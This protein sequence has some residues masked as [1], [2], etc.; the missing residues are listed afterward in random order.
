[1]SAIANHIVDLMVEKFEIPAESLDPATPFESLELDSL[2]LVELAVLL[3][4]LYGIA[5]DDWE[6]E[7]AAT[8]DGTV[9]LLHTKGLPVAA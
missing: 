9:E 3:Q 4:K 5:V 2:V 6:I 8:I 1:M 7:A